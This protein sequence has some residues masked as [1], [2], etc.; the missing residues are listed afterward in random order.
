MQFTC[1]MQSDGEKGNLQTKLI[2]A[3]RISIDSGQRTEDKEGAPEKLGDA[4]QK[5]G[6]I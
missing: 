1:R 3:K 4:C 2:K 5:Q 6:Q